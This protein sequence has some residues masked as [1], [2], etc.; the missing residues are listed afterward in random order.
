VLASD[1][2]GALQLKTISGDIKAE[3]FQKNVDVKTVSGDIS[4]RGRGQ[5]T[6]IH[7]GTISGNVHVDRAGGD[8]DATTVSGDMTVRLERAH[9]IRLRGTSGDIQFEGKLAKD[10]SVDAETVSG[11]VSIRGKPEGALDYEINTFS[12]DINDC[13][14]VESVRVSKYGPGHRLAGTTGADGARI[15]VKTMSGDVE[16]CDKS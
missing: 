12:G 8:F 14:G 4:L 11:D 7:I 13:M 9:L 15:R 16:L 10:G 2:Q 6:A 1:V 3:V 5:N